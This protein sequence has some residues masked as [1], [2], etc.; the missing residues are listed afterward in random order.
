MSR[1]LRITLMWL[2]ALAVPAQ[3]FAAASML[4]CGP[5][6]HGAADTR[7]HAGPML[8]APMD[9]HAAGMTRHSYVGGFDADKDHDHDASGSSVHGDLL[10]AHAGGKFTKGSCSVCA[11]CCM[12]CALPTEM[13]SFEATPLVDFFLPLAPRSVAPFLTDGPERPPRSVLA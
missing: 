4:G 6:Q 12:A 1:I 10:K 8:G 9:E 3:G 2:L 5:G 7:S 11:S 13:V